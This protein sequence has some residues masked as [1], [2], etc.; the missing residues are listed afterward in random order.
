[1]SK[2]VSRRILL[3]SGVD[4]SYLKL[5]PPAESVLVM[6]VTVAVLPQ[7]V[8][9]AILVIRIVITALGV[10]ASSTRDGVC[11]HSYLT[12]HDP[13]VEV[14]T[15]IKFWCSVGSTRRQDCP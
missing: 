10:P 5:L 9:I 4:K 11:L 14:N 7:V 6:N 1:M 3:M 15:R 12:I 2:T 13:M 8:V